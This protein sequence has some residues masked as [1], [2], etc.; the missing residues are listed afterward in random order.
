MIK[1]TGFG[2]RAVEFYDG[3]VVDN[4]RSYFAAHKSVYQV[5]V[6]QPMR[7]LL[8]ELS[9]EFGAGHLFRP[10]RDVRFSKDKSPY[11]DH[12]GGYVEHSEGIGYY[13]QLSSEGLLAAAGWWSPQPEQLARFRA[14]LDGPRAPHLARELDGFM[15]QGFLLDGPMLATRPRGVPADHPYLEL[16]R[17]KNMTASRTFSAPSWIFEPKALAHVRQTWQELTPLVEL[18]SEL[19]EPVG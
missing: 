14:A 4:S 6:E 9:E 17:R 5:D 16:M 10:H 8:E 2:E 15:R 3:L 18:L 11:K 19:V 13:V 1:F 7:A 12:Q